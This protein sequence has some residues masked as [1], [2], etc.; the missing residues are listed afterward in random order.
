[1]GKY[2]LLFLF[3]A[4]SAFAWLSGWGYRTEINISNP[5]SALSDYQVQVNP[6][7]C[8]NTGLVGSWHFNENYGNVNE[9][10]SCYD[11]ETRIF[12]KEGW[13]LVL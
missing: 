8:N 3:F 12:T 11:N 13:K 2:R 7:I 6:Q 4:G 1:M 9:G 10:H 5:G